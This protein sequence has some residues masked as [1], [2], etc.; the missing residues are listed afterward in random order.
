MPFPCS[1]Y[2]T[3]QQTRGA[4]GSTYRLGPARSGTGSERKTGGRHRDKKRPAAFTGSAGLFAN[5]I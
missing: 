5:Q 1:N 2:I 4:R 3:I